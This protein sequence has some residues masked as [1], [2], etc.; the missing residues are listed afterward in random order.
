MN[1][2][3]SRSDPDGA[4]WADDNT[5]RLLQA[6]AQPLAPADRSVELIL[7]SDERIREINREFRGKDLATDVIS[8]SYVDAP[9]PATE[10]DLAGEIYVSHE[11][12]EKEAKELGVDSTDLFL[13]VG[14][15]GLLHVVGYDHEDE[16]DAE[17]MESRER[18]VLAPHLSAATLDALF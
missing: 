13:R 9:G 15:H 4:L 11:T 12:L 7:V 2:L 16:A 18:E 17:R 10:I 5:V 6:I 3:L 1:L 8:F 14:V